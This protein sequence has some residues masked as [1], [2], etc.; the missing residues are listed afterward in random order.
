MNEY[1]LAAAFLTGV[2]CLMGTVAATVL[3]GIPGFVGTC[4][5]LMTLYLVTEPR[6]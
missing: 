5:F 6:D 3:F 4:L 2:V 1:D